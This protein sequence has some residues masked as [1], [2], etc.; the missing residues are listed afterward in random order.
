MVVSIAALL[1]LVLKVICIPELLR[2]RTLNGNPGL[3][4]GKARNN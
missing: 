4:F 1:T 3:T 2:F